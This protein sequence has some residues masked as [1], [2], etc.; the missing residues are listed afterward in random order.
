MNPQ[1]RTAWQRVAQNRLWDV[2]AA[3]LVA[4]S[5]VRIGRVLPVAATGNDFAHFYVSSRLLL[6]GADVYATPME[7]RYEKFGFVFDP[8]IPTAAYPPSALWL[9][10]PVAL[11]PPKP[12][13]AVWLTG[14]IVCLAVI[15]WLTHRLVGGRMGRRAWWFVV[16]GVLVSATVFWHFRYSQMQLL[17]ACLVLA[18]YAM[19]RAGRG[20]PACAMVAVAGV[21]KLYPFALAPWFVWRAGKTWRERSVAG[22][23][24][25]VVAGGVWALTGP[26]L[27]REFFESGLKMA[28]AGEVN[29][30]FHYSV[31]ALVANLGLATGGAERFWWLTG[32]VSGAGVIALAYGLCWWRRGEEET[33]FCF[34]S[35]A[36]LAGLITTQG[37]YFVFLVLPVA[38]AIAGRRFVWL[39]AA[40]VIALN[41]QMT[42]ELRQPVA[43]VWANNV[44]L[45]GLLVMGVFFGCELWRAR[46]Q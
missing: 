6:E 11:M 24:V 37:Q 38:V 36:M 26:G 18:G 33:E 31:A 16:A 30:S 44:P 39:L 32:N 1:P 28:A 25:T 7:S 23:V 45:A 15:L 14:E 34:M 20:L 10:A 13:F 19:L 46:A 21:L 17:L 5:V 42:W 43:V 35:V 4:L 2:A 29:R 8:E 41:L 9:M 12:A 40:A 27:W 3:V 22:L